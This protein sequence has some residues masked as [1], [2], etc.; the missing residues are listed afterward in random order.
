M[1]AMLRVAGHK[2]ARGA[3]RGDRGYAM[4]ADHAARILELCKAIL[5]MVDETPPTDPAAYLDHVAEIADMG[6]ELA[7]AVKFAIGANQ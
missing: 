1:G 2:G 6:V 7:G 3:G 5:D 4:T